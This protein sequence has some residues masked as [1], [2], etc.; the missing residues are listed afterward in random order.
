MEILSETAK[1]VS[2]I[3]YQS[4]KFEAAPYVILKNNGGCTEHSYVTM[5]LLRGMGIPTRLVW[6]YLPTESS[7]EMSFNHK[8]VE[9]WVDG[10]G[11]IPL[12]PLAPPKSKPGVTHARHLVF[13]VLPKPTHPKIV[14][15][16]RLVQIAKDQIPLGKQ[17]KMKLTILKK[18]TGDRLEE[19]IGIQPNRIRTRAIQAGEDLVVP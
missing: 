13:A 7:S 6:N 1:Y 9:V 17:L 5:S 12:E 16:D 4:G 18:E 19:E 11:W 14:G 8:Y 3:P 15:G 2:S 10:L